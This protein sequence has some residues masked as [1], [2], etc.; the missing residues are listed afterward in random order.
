[1][2]YYLVT[3]NPKPELL[4]ELRALLAQNAFVDLRPFGRA[5]SASLRAARRH[6]DGTLVWEEEDYC[7]PPLAQERAAVLD[8]FFDSLEVEPVRAGAGW[9]RIDALPPIF[10]ELAT[11]G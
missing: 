9:E 1:M 4:D 6:P 10:P 8:R 3:A 2:A 7:R 5:L 11:S